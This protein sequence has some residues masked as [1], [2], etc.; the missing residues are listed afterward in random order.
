MGTFFSFFLSFAFFFF[1]F[2]VVLHSFPF[3]STLARGFGDRKSQIFF[4]SFFFKFQFQCYGQLGWYNQK[5]NY[6]HPTPNDGEDVIIQAGPDSNMFLAFAAKGRFGT[7]A[8]DF[9]ARTVFHPLPSP[10]P[11]VAI[12]IKRSYETCSHMPDRTEIGAFELTVPALVKT[13]TE[14]S[15]VTVTQ[16]SMETTTVEGACSTAATAVGIF[17]LSSRTQTLAKP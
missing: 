7:C 13:M 1:S 4:F 15:L 16:L 12:H 14:V 17:F 6:I 2:L 9:A 8:R 11:F 5:D 10:P 3:P